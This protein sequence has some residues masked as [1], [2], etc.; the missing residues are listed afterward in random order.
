MSFLR[1][2][3]NTFVRHWLTSLDILKT[4]PHKDGF[5]DKDSKT[6]ETLEMEAR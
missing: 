4:F 6:M 5:K 1:R 3:I 2:L